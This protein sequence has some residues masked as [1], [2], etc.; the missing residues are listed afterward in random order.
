M[1]RNECMNFCEIDTENGSLYFCRLACNKYCL[2]G[3]FTMCSDYEPSA[4]RKRWLE[5]SG[6]AFIKKEEFQV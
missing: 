5:L 2:E 1:F 4:D 3:P 6:K